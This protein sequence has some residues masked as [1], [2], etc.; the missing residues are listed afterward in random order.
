M[1]SNRTTCICGYSNYTALIPIILPKYLIVKCF[2]HNCK[3][4][5]KQ[6]LTDLQQYKIIIDVK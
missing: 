4:E 1:A 3:K 5:T 6:I 2:C